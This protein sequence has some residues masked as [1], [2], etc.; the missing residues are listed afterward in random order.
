MVGLLGVWKIALKIVVHAAFDWSL[1][2]ILQLTLF[3]SAIV[4]TE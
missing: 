4:I 2:T 1:I 3:M